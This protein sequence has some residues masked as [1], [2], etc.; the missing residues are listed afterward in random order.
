MFWIQANSFD[1]THQSIMK[2]ARALQIEGRDAPDADVFELVRHNLEKPERGRWVMIIDHADDSQSLTLPQG[3]KKLHKRIPDCSHGSVLLTT[4][5]KKVATL[6]ADEL[7]EVPPLFPKESEELMQQLLKTK[8]YQEGGLDEL[9][10]LLNHFPLALVQ[11]A[12]FI[13]GN[14]MTVETYLQRYHENKNDALEVFGHSHEWDDSEPVT[15]TWMISFKQLQANNQYAADLLSTMAFLD[16]SDIP[17]ALIR[18][19]DPTK[20]P[21]QFEE[22]CG[23]LKAFSFITETSIRSTTSANADSTSLSKWFNIQLIV[24]LVM[25]QWLRKHGQATKWSDAA[26]VAVSKAL[27]STEMSHEQWKTYETY[28]PHVQT[29]LNHV[30]DSTQEPKCRAD[31]LHNVSWYFRIRGYHDTAAAMACDAIAIRERIL[32]EEDEDTLASIR[33]LCRI[34]FEQGKLEESEQRLMPAI[35]ICKRKFGEKHKDTLQNQGH[36]AA[37]R[38]MQGRYEEAFELQSEILKESC[39]GP[40]AWIAMRDLAITLIYMNRR[41]EAESLQ[42]MVYRK[43]LE[44]LGEDHPETQVIMS[45]LATTC[46][47][48]GNFSEAE[49]LLISVLRHSRRILGERHPHTMAAYES[50]KDVLQSQGNTEHVKRLEDALRRVQRDWKQK[51][52]NARQR[53]RPDFKRRISSSVIT[54]SYRRPSAPTEDVDANGKSR[55]ESEGGIRG[56]GLTFSRSTTMTTM[57]MSEDGD[58]YRDGFEDDDDDEE[59]DDEREETVKKGLAMALIKILG[60]PL[61]NIQFVNRAEDPMTPFTPIDGRKQSLSTPKISIDDV[62]SVAHGGEVSTRARSATDATSVMTLSDKPKYSNNVAIRSIQKKTERTF[63]QENVEKT[64]VASNEAYVKTVQQGAEW[65]EKWKKTKF[66]KSI[67]AVGK[68][69]LNKEDRHGDDKGDDGENA[70]ERPEDKGNGEDN[71]EDI[72]DEG[73]GEIVAMARR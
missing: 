51:E 14:D 13:D 12:S 10:R 70:E 66:R 56:L 28:L 49:E 33:S 46:I 54:Y 52:K 16:S 41:A 48:Q 8:H 15:T 27:P 34:L 21:L 47:E 18:G 35:E 65:Y 73:K 72:P 50:L 67:A 62:A 55:R 25:Q 32:G 17:E 2:I 38:G 61:N 20:T 6:F 9:T 68:K 31:L 42:R 40:E 44:N 7:E 5:N 26:L 69:A 58:D 23:E 71:S 60:M 29:V 45:D 1:H 24:Q 53:Q 19:V 36:L 4:R 39:E 30:D 63:N 37:I 64:L 3:G 22:A 57:S 43:R 11:A 59:N